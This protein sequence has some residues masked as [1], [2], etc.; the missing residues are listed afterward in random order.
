VGF[1]QNPRTDEGRQGFSRHEFDPLAETLLQQL[2]QG[3]EAI[4][5][6]GTWRKLYKQ[7]DIAVWPGLVTK[8]RP[9]EGEPSHAKST[10]VGLK[11]RERVNRLLSCYCS[12]GTTLARFPEEAKTP[13]RQV[14]TTSG[15]SRLALTVPPEL[16]TGLYEQLLTIELQRLISALETGRVNLAQPEAAD[17]HVS[18]ANHLRRVLERALRAFP[19]DERLAGQAELC[20]ALIDWLKD[21]RPGS[22][23]ADEALVV[24]LTMLREVRTLTQGA[25]FGGA[26]PEPLVPLSSSDLLVNARGEPSVGSVIER[27]VHRRSRTCRPPC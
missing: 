4:V 13:G 23:E 21:E 3:Q 20:N 22:V 2:R 26:I 25:G 12:H 1:G 9:E 7:V 11:R 17:A 5:C 27:E 8:H 14:R 16:I 19:E 10:N 15:H 6:L 24:P 18:V